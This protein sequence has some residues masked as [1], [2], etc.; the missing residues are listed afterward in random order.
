MVGTCNVAEN[1]VEIILYDEKGDTARVFT[2]P[3]F[4][5]DGYF[6]AG[7]EKVEG[8]TTY[9]VDLV[10]PLPGEFEVLTTLPKVISSVT[11]PSRV[12]HS[13]RLWCPSVTTNPPR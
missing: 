8:P 4:G 3:V 10:R 9:Y 13:T 1:G 12:T 6:V 11:S 7:I 5:R 2:D